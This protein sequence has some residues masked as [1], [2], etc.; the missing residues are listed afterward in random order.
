MIRGRLIVCVASAWDYDPT[1]K[2][3]VMKILARHNDVLWVNYHGTR[4]PRLNGADVR[5]SFRALGRVARGVTPISDSMWQVTPLVAPG[6]RHALVAGASQILLER[7][8]K[9][10]IH[11][12][13]PQRKRPVQLW[14]FAPDVPQLFG[15]FNEECSIYYCVD[16]FSEFAGINAERVRRS[17]AATLERADVVV[18]TSQALLD[19][20]RATRPDT[21]LMPHGVDFDHFATAWRD[22]L[23]VPHDIRPIPRPILGFFGMIEHWIDIGL[24]ADVARRRPNYSFVLIGDQRTDVSTLRS[25]PNVFL[26]GR[27]QYQELPRY[28]A[29]FDAALLPFVQST[30]T[31][32]VNPI[33]MHEYLAAG[34]RVVSC[35]LPEAARYPEHILSVDGAGAFASACDRVLAER[36]HHPRYVVAR[37]VHGETWTSRVERLSELVTRAIESS[38]GTKS[39]AAIDLLPHSGPLVQNSSQARVIAG[40]NAR[41]TTTNTR[42]RT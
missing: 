6:A 3:H 26:T 39:R 11:R 9:R 33:K 19:S 22:A 21:V 32:N 15:R 27:R 12:I 1:S 42:A 23:P 17:E 14:T 36:I 41:E 25:L 8:I 40:H 35:G 4:R 30:M 31:R 18:T 20:R 7:Q 10:A 24:L 13:D 34:L 5:G 2:H 38:S 37:T 16:E 29:A 28:A